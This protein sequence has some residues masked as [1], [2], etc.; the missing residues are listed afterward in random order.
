MAAKAA[1]SGPVSWYRAAA[2]YQGCLM[3]RERAGL[4]CR[5]IDEDI[6]RLD[7]LVDETT[8][9]QLAKRGR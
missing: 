1:R 6:G 3:S 4:P 9:V 8:F 5:G 7:I 2:R